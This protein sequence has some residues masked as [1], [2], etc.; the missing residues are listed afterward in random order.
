VSSN[1]NII[2][3]LRNAVVNL[4]VDSARATAEEAV[5]LGVNPVEAIE[6]G[7]SKGIREIGD[8]FEA[9][10][11][12]VMEL[13]LAAEAM[14]AGIEVFRPLLAAQRLERK[15]TG[16]VVIGTVRGD[17]HDMGKN[18]VIVM[19]EAAGF[20]VKDLGV[21]VPP[22]RFLEKVKEEKPHIIAMSSLLTT[23]APEQKIVVDA[24]EK[25]GIRRGLKVAV[26]GAAVTPK[27]AKEMGADGYSDNAVD[28]VAVFKQLMSS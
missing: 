22:E 18:L 27:L 10:E 7:L 6:N 24:L 3:E 17:I 5:R 16:I 11:A 12:F 13:V 14:K 2:E 19:L 26:G 21:D 25:N 28:S 20:D 4:D 1:S 8:K 23:S 15:A 9:G